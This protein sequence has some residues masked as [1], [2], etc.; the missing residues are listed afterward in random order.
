MHTRT[1]TGM[2]VAHAQCTISSGVEK[3][4]PQSLLHTSCF[5]TAACH[6]V[7]WPQMLVQLS[8]AR[9]LCALQLM[10]GFMRHCTK[11]P[12]FNME[13]SWITV[14]KPAS[15]PWDPMVETL[16]LWLACPNNVSHNRL[17]STRIYI[18]FWG[19]SAAIDLWQLLWSNTQTT[20]QLW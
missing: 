6:I 10:H 3:E 13:I 16:L 4:R 2:H 20:L 7:W 17:H 5:S 9:S 11:I 8:A 15:T 1:Y 14:L 18:H 19:A 12:N